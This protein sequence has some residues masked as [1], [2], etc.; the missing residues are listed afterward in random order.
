MTSLQSYPGKG[1]D[2]GKTFFRIQPYL[3]DGRRVTIRLG[4]GEK[5]ASRASKAIADLIDSAKA[6]VE[7]NAKTKAWIEK[8]VSLQL[9]E[10]LITCGL[11]QELPERLSGAADSRKV[12][13]SQISDQYIKTRGAG[14]SAETITIYRKS[15]KNL[16]SCFGDV[17]IRAVKAKDGRE[18]WRWLIEEGNAKVKKGE[19]KGLSSNTAKQRLRFAR[20]FFQQ[21]IE[22]DIIEKNPFKVSGLTTSQTAA[23]KA[24][25]SWKVIDDVIK[26]CP[27]LEWKLLFTLVRTIPTRVPSEIE[28][29]TWADVDVE[30]NTLLIHSPKTRTIG[31]SARL[32]P[33]LEPLKSMLADAYAKAAFGEQYVFPTLRLNKNPATTAKKYVTKAKKEIWDNFFNSLRASAE[34]D[35]MDEYGL[36]RACQWAGNS[37]ATAMKNY[38]LVRKTDFVDSGNSVTKSDAKSDAIGAADAKSDAES[39]NMGEQKPHE[40]STVK[41]VESSQCFKVGAKGLEPLTPSV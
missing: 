29:L 20:A 19:V 33:L 27:T 10:T 1:K 28:E 32:V 39:D 31:K 41:I 2:A 13:I 23:E 37:P 34:T 21:A 38:A 26:Q 35:L 9:C 16:I 25:V 18:F 6:D 3:P 14:Q 36:R 17:D 5:Q 7:P 30:K 15:K 8:T 12:L 11:V 40:K 4:T 22:D 24:Y